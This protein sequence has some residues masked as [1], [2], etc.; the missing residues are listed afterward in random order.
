M[1]NK[2]S[3][4]ALALAL[5]LGAFGAMAAEADLKK[6]EELMRQGR[7][8]DAYNL[9]QPLTT[10]NAGNVDFDYLLG[11]AALD[12]GRPDEAL[13]AFERVLAVNPAHMGARLDMGRTFFAMGSLDLA[14]QEFERVRAANPPPAARNVVDKYLAAIEERSKEEKRRLTGY[15]EAGAGYDDNITSVTSAFQSGSQQAF[16]FV[17]LDPTGNAV[18]RRAPFLNIG[19]GLDFYGAVTD[20]FAIT[21]GI[22]AKQRYHEPKSAPQDGRP[23]LAGEGGPRDNSA[24]DSQTIDLRV[25]VAVKLD[26]RTLFN[27]NLKRQ[28]FRQDGDTPIN[29]A[30][31]RATADRDT[32]ALAYD[33][34]YAL[35]PESQAGVFFQYAN[36]RMLTINTQDTD[37]VVLGLSYLHAFQRQGNPVVFVSAFQSDDYALRPQ[38]PPVNSTD[39]SKRVRGLRFYGQYSV[40]G[41][42]DLFTALGYSRREDQTDYS[43]TARGN[44][45]R[46]GID[47]TFEVGLGVNWR[48][49]P[50]WSLRG[51]VQHTKNESNLELYSFKRT[52]TSVTVRR[53]FR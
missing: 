53:E 44:A 3:V 45:I 20:T 50:L 46:L 43:R 37:Q 34:R 14:K 48:F 12:S 11:I 52:E 42:A 2:I 7:A 6:A 36:N 18:R 38:D 17:G 33:V 15:L 8:A 32:N 9:L 40:A 1:H 19:G 21:A 51:Q 31:P 35:T 29:P 25:G 23:Q 4:A 22:D 27:V 26:P 28:E 13:N 16:G 10:Q 24:Y 49:A 39:V 30:Q 5:L 47:D 41:N